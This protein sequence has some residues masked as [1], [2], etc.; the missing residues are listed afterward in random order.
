MEQGQDESSAYAICRTSL[1][2][3]ADGSE[4]EKVITASWDDIL[5]NVAPH[6]E[7][8]PNTTVAKKP[9]R[10]VMSSDLGGMASSPDR[11]SEVQ[12]VPIGEWSGYQQEDPDTGKLRQLK[13]KVGEN[14]I[15]AMTNNFD[16]LGRDLVID[17]E[18]QTL[19][20]DQAPAAGWIK[21]LI[22]KG[23]EGL[24]AVVEWTDQALKYLRNKE[25][26]FLSPVFTLDGIDPKSGRKVG[27]M[28]L[29]AALTNQPFFSELKPIVSTSKS[30]DRNVGPSGTADKNV[31][32]T[33]IFLTQEEST[34]KK[35][36]AKLIATF[37]LAEAATEDEVLAKLEQH[38]TT[39]QQIIAGRAEV[40]GVLG[41]KAEAT[42]ADLKA[43]VVVAKG[44][45]AELARALEL[46]PEA[47]VEEIKAAIVV[48]KAGAGQL[49][50]MA[51]RVQA[52]EAKDFER[53]FN[54]IIDGAFIAGKIL[55]VQMN[56]TKWIDA[57]KVLAKDIKAFEE[58]WGKQPVIGPVQKIP[59]YG[60]PVI[61]GKGD[62]PE[63]ETIGKVLGVTAE[64]R[65]K[66]N[67]GTN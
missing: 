4:D 53:E 56:D 67:P 5:K 19:T 26:R 57:Q 46:K 34:M 49:P 16:W 22:N 24:W 30:T 6:L 32:P 10:L 27:A 54:R 42:D 48:A 9:Q 58:F 20:G 51:A 61:A 47:T 1:A 3:S 18:H 2:L 39:S 14:D 66:W 36:I 63:D 59:T 25:Y 11:M 31:G 60:E 17:Y 65:K 64:Q 43:A 33:A 52:L 23:K 12:L 50:Q 35:V 7:K 62:T 37:K 38:L 45:I 21:R 41:L 44:N 28:L 15:A 40:I 55:P 29:N 8:K 13:F